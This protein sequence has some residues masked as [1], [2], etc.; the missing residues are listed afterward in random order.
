[1]VRQTVAAAC[2]TLLLGTGVSPGIPA[3]PPP[4]SAAGGGNAPG[5]AAPGSTAFEPP[6]RARV[7]QP[8]DT[9][10]RTVAAGESV[11]VSLPSSVGGRRVRA[12]RI[13]RA[14]ALS[15]VADRSFAWA[16][17]SVPARTHDILLRA[18]HDTAAPDTLVLR[19]DVQ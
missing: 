9:L 11:V 18:E 2:I 15:G 12:Y 8:P 4:V 16:T 5:A 10:R 17:E 14:P 6:A 19:L 3:D 13:L 7:A 1:M